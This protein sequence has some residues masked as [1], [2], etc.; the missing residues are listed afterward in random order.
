[1]KIKFILLLCLGLSAELAF[2]QKAKKSELI[3]ILTTKF[4]K[5][6]FIL[7]DQTPK[8]K[9]NFTKLVQQKYFDSIAFHRVLKNFVVQ[10]GDPSTKPGADTSQI[11]NGGPG[12][13]IDA[14]IVASFKHLRGYIGAARQS[15]EINP[16]RRSSGSQFYIVQKA[17][18][19]PH[20]DGK[21][22]VFGK[23]ISGMDVVDKIASVEVNKAGR[24]FE[25]IDMTIRANKVKIKKIFKLYGIKLE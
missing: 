1:M 7:F 12:Y 3:F 21:Y 6:E 17:E 16:Q 2:G 4:G 23:V 18:G 24:P 22:T 20:L 14:E 11:G 19:T 9:E 15:D 10:G 25:R 8:H 5:I 13:E